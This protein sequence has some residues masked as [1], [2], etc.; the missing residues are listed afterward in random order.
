VP[1]IGAYFGAPSVTINSVGTVARTIRGGDP[2]RS[3][4]ADCSLPVWPVSGSIRCRV[5]RSLKTLANAAGG[6]AITS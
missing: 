5:E 2:L 4:G 3:E 6:D 1:A